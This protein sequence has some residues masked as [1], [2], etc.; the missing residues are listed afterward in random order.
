[1][2]QGQ[3]KN[4]TTITVTEAVHSDLKRVKPYESMSYDELIRE[5]MKEY[6]SSAEGQ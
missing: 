3:A 1:M 4:W 5:M 6:E 2:A